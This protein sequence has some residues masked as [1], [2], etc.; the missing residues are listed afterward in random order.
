MTSSSTPSSSTPSSSS[1]IRPIVEV[2]SMVHFGYP[3]SDDSEQ[4]L[5]L[6]AVVTEIHIG[7]IVRLCVFSTFGTTFNLSQVEYSDTLKRGHWSWP[8]SVI[9]KLEAELRR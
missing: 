9:Q 4:H 3:N 7:S 6:P 2:G 1:L 5:L 8:P